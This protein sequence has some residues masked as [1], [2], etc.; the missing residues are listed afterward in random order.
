MDMFE[1]LS[2]IYLSVSLEKYLENELQ[3]EEDDIN[4]DQIISDFINIL[5]KIYEV[6]NKPIVIANIK[7][8]DYDS[9]GNCEL[10]QF[11][12][13]LIH[14]LETYFDKHFVSGG[15]N[16]TPERLNS[17][18]KSLYLHSL[19]G[20]EESI[21]NFLLYQDNLCS[22]VTDK[23][24]FYGKE[25][26][27]TQGTDYNCILIFFEKEHYD[28][29]P[30]EMAKALLDKEKFAM[31][32]K[33]PES[34]IPKNFQLSC[35][36]PL[37]LQYLKKFKRFE[38][39]NCDLKEFQDRF[40]GTRDFCG[41]APQD[42]TRISSG[43]NNYFNNLFKNYLQHI[44]RKVH[45]FLRDKLPHINSDRRKPACPA[46]QLFKI[47]STEL[48]DNV[49]EHLKLFTAFQKEIEESG[50]EKD[51][52]FILHQTYENI[53]NQWSFLEREESFPFFSELV[54]KV[55]QRHAKKLLIEL[56]ESR[57]YDTLTTQQQV[58][59]ET[60]VG[61]PI[62]SPVKK[63]ISW[64]IKLKDYQS[65]QAVMAILKYNR[66]KTAQENLNLFHEII[67]GLVLN[68][69][70][71]QKSNFV[72]TITGFLCSP[73]HPHDKFSELC[74]NNLDANDLNIMSLTQYVPNIGTL[75]CFVVSPKATF[76]NIIQILFQITRALKKARGNLQFEHGN[77]TASNILIVEASQREDLHYVIDENRIHLDKVRYIPVIKDYR[78][79]RITH[80]KKEVIPFEQI[81]L[82][83]EETA[84]ITDENRDIIRLLSSLDQNA[85]FL[86]PTF[87]EIMIQFG[88]AINAVTGPEKNK[89]FQDELKSVN[90]FSDLLSKMP[91]V[92]DTSPLMLSHE[93]ITPSIF[94]SPSLTSS[95]SVLRSTPT[96]DSGFSSPI[97][98]SSSSPTTLDSRFL[99]KGSTR[100]L[101][102]PTK[103]STRF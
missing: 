39:S 27:L 22:P 21:K 101:T 41:V 40:C 48:D 86:G 14:L 87:D 47:F 68:R 95:P 57:I 75:E 37:L 102:P 77:L 63:T 28:P 58:F 34:E 2:M 54:R 20:G 64:A 84:N 90:F 46:V 9:I 18:L 35:N 56:N 88:N 45:H 43:I 52:N 99:T 60:F 67:V 73:P 15:T 97:F 44:Q 100:F 89:D 76:T 12:A 62:I 10:K 16:F 81:S 6:K 3:E 17:Q 96:R 61:R 24:H 38:E 29:F 78:Y 42:K 65:S 5:D 71:E 59:A 13:V 26:T 74:K 8:R 103:G 70:I 50:D 85:S 91:K 51:E 36:N 33:L 53:Y 66:K 93:R 1:C 80:E 49:E 23:T 82:D 25:N 72:Y 11:T 55:L 7:N 30:E 19:V 69:I 31:L 98:S 92:Y 94:L 4:P 79:A 83:V 32:F